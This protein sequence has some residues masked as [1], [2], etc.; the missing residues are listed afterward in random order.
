MISEEGGRLGGNFPGVSKELTKKILRMALNRNQASSVLGAKRIPSK[1]CQY[2]LKIPRELLKKCAG[3]AK[4]FRRRNLK[5]RK[6]VRCV[7]NWQLHS[8]LHHG[9]HSDVRHIAR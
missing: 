2:L 4:K 6:T 7:S 1:N 8:S 3:T 5:K 9:I